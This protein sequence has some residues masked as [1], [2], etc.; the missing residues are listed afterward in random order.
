MEGGAGKSKGRVKGRKR[1]RYLGGNLWGNGAPKVRPTGTRA[2]V[3][4]S[5]PDSI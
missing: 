4:K 5:P 2:G 3:G 1:E